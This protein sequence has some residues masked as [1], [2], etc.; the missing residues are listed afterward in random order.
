MG[1][2]GRFLIDNDPA[3]PGEA[4][5][6][7]ASA[8]YFAAMGIPLLRGRFFDRSDTVNSPHVALITQ[9]L[10]ARY[11]PN[12]NPIGKRIQ[13]G[14]MDTDKRLLHVVGVVGDT[15]NAGLENE[16]GP[17]VYAFSLQRPQWW[18]VSRLSIVARA[19]NQPQALIPAMRAAVA[20][21]RADVPLSFKTL[22]QV[23]SS[24]FDQRR[25]S[26]AIFA[27]VAAVALLIGA[28]GIY[29]VMSYLVTQRTHEI[30]IRMALGARAADVLW[31]ALGHGM[32]LAIMGVA[33]GMVASSAL[34]RLLK[35]LLYGVGASDPITFAAI[36]LFLLLVALL[37]CWIPARRATRIDPMVALRRE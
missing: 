23:F 3:Q 10:A 31:M 14:N 37:A 17:T 6:R 21:L 8:G 7:V 2:N 13:F 33:L 16:A 24:S 12:E 15:R 27:A 28:A 29:S 18:Q 1:A 25:F 4:E 34:T 36:A 35:S 22:E 19:T 26:L 9:S 11:W 30:G 5:Y 32:K 20:A